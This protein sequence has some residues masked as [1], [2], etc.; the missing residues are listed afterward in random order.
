MSTVVTGK[1]YTVYKYLHSECSGWHLE[2]GNIVVYI[3]TRT[4]FDMFGSQLSYDICNETDPFV[5]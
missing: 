3:L 1:Y 4:V 2:F 5:V